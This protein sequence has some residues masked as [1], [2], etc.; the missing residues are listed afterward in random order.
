MSKFQFFYMKPFIN[1]CFISMNDEIHIIAT[2]EVDS[3]AHIFRKCLK[4]NA[5]IIKIFLVCPKMG[6]NCVS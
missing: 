2:L 6:E 1:I 3:F 5:V 4:L